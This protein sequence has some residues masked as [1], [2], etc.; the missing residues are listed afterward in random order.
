MAVGHDGRIQAVGTNDDPRFLEYTM[1]NDGCGGA[2]ADA[3]ENS[4]GIVMTFEV[5][6]SPNR[7]RFELFS[8]WPN[9]SNERQVG[10]VLPATRLEWRPE[11]RLCVNDFDRCL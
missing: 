8:S 4:G 9:F 7:V 5:Q 2:R 10:S 1:F 3:A 11:H 6:F